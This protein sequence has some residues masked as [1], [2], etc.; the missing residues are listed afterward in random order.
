MKTIV[1][2]HENFIRRAEA[3]IIP[4]AAQNLPVIVTDKWSKQADGSMKKQYSFID[5]S[6][7][8]SFLQQVLDFEESSGHN[9]RILV[10]NEKVEISLITANVNSITELDKEYARFAD[11]VH[12]ELYYNSLP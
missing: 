9:A 11:S 4:R 10:E 12:R 5:N 8:N 7:R 1:D 2:L 3:P 6:A